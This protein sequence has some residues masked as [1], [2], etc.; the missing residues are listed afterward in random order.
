MCL[1]HLKS[2][3]GT[4]S[5]R[6]NQ[7]SVTENIYILEEEEG[8]TWSKAN[9]KPPGEGH[10]RVV[11]DVKKRHLAVLLSQHKENLKKKVTCV[12]KTKDI[13]NI[14]VSAI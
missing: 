11:V 5:V 10:D 14:T 12:Q 9:T 6:N 7:C 2:T 3:S 1:D 8:S 13:G 4:E